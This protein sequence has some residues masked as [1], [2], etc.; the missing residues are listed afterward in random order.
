MVE[1]EALTMAAPTGTLMIVPLALQ[2][3]AQMANLTAAET[4]VQAALV[5]ILVDVPTVAP[6]YVP[7]ILNRSLGLVL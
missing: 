6:M 7:P 5:A 1:S 4:A 3:V 2:V